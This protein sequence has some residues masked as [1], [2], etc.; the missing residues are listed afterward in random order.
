MP[1]SGGLAAHSSEDAAERSADLTF[2][3]L[4]RADGTGL[5]ASLTWRQ[6]T[7]GL[8]LGALDGISPWTAPAAGGPDAERHWIARTRLGYGIARRGSTGT[9]AIATPL[10]ELDSGHSDRGGGR[11]GVHHEF[12]DGERGLVVEWGIERRSFFAGAETGSSW[13]F[14]DGSDV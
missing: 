14:S 3:I 9:H 12:G 4:P 1:E 10:V 8:R 5:Q 13:G 11:F 2:S 6:E 7:G